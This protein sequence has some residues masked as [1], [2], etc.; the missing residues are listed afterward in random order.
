MQRASLFSSGE[1]AYVANRGTTCQPW[2]H[3]PTM[4]MYR[5]PDRS[6]GTHEI[7]LGQVRSVSCGAHDR[8]IVGH[9]HGHA[10][11]PGWYGFTGP[12]WTSHCRTDASYFFDLSLSAPPKRRGRVPAVLQSA[13][14]AQGRTF[15][16]QRS[17]HQRPGPAARGP[18]AITHGGWGQ[19][20]PIA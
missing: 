12:H 17:Y 10:T 15:A 11:S 9:E 8:S 4:Y 18:S 2:H 13:I 3:W 19:E 7:G 5:P 16:Y 14:S 1:C 20:R 6:T